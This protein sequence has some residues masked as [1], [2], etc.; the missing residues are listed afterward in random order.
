MA[1]YKGAIKS[2]NWVENWEF[3]LFIAA[4]YK[5]KNPEGLTAILLW[6]IFIL[7]SPQY[8]KFCILNPGESKFG[9][10]Q[11][12]VFWMKDFF[13]SVQLLSQPV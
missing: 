3:W 11:A 10:Q 1:L 8:I 7:I 6:I 12:R 4:T 2:H 9:H 13:L 5:A